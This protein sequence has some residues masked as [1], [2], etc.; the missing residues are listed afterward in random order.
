MLNTHNPLYSYLVLSDGVLEAR[1]ILETNLRA[2]LVVLSACETG[3]GA[4]N[5]GEGLVG[6]SWAFQLAGTPATVVSQW[7]VD[8][9]GTAELMLA[10]HRAW[11]IDRA[12]PALAL[13][14]AALETM[15]NPAWRHPFY[16]AAFVLMGAG[17]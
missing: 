15:K 9:A 1:E 7:K 11:R 8:S 3:L 4:L 10:F 6:M 5:S 13:Q 16:W 12:A 14:H 17:Y 2:R